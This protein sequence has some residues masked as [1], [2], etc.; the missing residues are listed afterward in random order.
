MQNPALARWHAHLHGLATPI[1][2]TSK[3]TINAADSRAFSFAPVPTVRW[4][5]R[6]HSFSDLQY[7]RVIALIQAVD[8]I[9]DI[10]Y[11]RFNCLACD[12]P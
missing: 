12:S 9:L 7:I 6:F 2:E 5:D 4:Y 11:Y 1:D 10:I 8:F 3:L